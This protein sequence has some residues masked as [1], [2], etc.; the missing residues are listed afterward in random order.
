MLVDAKSNDMLDEQSSPSAPNATDAR[1]RALERELLNVAERGA[2]GSD[3]R[4]IELQRLAERVR[5][6]GLDLPV[7][8]PSRAQNLAEYILKLHY[9][10]SVVRALG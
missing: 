1:L 3:A 5:S 10:V 9:C 6:T 8:R 4:G 2:S 7:R